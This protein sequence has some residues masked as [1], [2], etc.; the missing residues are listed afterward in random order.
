MSVGFARTH[1][2][3]VTVSRVPLLISPEGQVN[4][5]EVVTDLFDAIQLGLIPGARLITLTG[6]RENISTAYE[7][8]AGGT[9]SVERSDTPEAITCDFANGNDTAAGTGA[10]T[11]LV[12]YVNADGWY[13]LGVCPATGLAGAVVYEAKAT[14]K[15]NDTQ[16]APIQ[17]L[18][19][20]TGIRVMRAYV[21]SA[22][23][24]A[25][26]W[27]GSNAGAIT[28]KIG[29]RPQTVISAGECISK[30]S[31]V[32]SPRGFAGFVLPFGWGTDE[33]NR[34][35]VEVR[36]KPWGKPV[37]RYQKVEASRGVALVPMSGKIRI[38]ARGD[39]WLLGEQ[40]EGGPAINLSTVIQMALIPDPDDLDGDD[41]TL[42]PPEL[43]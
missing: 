42:H 11:V 1:N 20:A 9:G 5:A 25:D 40:I 22:G 16:V 35:L 26:G 7:A 2:G 30:E 10:R 29:T 4:R 15:G 21:P 28:V 24:S 33:A 37:L 34:G 31:A 27:T 38:G 13:R 19:P 14:G 3:V 32:H 43:G 23:G 12:E 41:P 8:W 17:P 39:L 36:T 6:R 18:T